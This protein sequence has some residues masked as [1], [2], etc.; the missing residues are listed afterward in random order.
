MSKLK[1][2]FIQTFFILILSSL[3]SLKAQTMNIISTDGSIQTYSITLD[4]KVYFSNDN[5]IFDNVNNSTPIAQIRKIIFDTTSGL[6]DTSQS[7]SS[8]LLVTPN[9]AKD[10]IY[11][12]NMPAGNCLINIYSITGTYI[13]A[14]NTNAFSASIDIS[15]L[16][17][18]VYIIRVNNLTAKFIKL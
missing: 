15:A 16:P 3:I 2:L 9:P 18:G 6:V 7:N 4:S 17:E 1:F 10:F 8:K 13:I 11:I 5:L 12:K 14:T